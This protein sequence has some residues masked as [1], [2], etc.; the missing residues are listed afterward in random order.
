MDEKKVITTLW[1]TPV[2]RCNDTIGENNVKRYAGNPVGNTP[3]V[4]LLDNSLNQDLHESVK[5]HVAATFHV[6]PVHGEK[7]LLSTPTQNFWHINYAG[8]DCHLQH[9]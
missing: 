1:I 7:F 5:T 9:G 6:A 3:E 8:K 4:M 2:L